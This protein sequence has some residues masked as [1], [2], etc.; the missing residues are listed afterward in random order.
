MLIRTDADC[1]RK[2]V[3][4]QPSRGNSKHPRIAV[5]VTFSA[6]R[7]RLE[8]VCPFSSGRTL[9]TAPETEILAARRPVQA[10]WISLSGHVRKNA[11]WNV[12]RA[13]RLLRVVV[14]PSSSGPE[15]MVAPGMAVLAARPPVSGDSTS[16][17]GHVLKTVLGA[18]KRARRLLRAVT[19][20]SFR[21]PEL[22]VVLGTVQR[23]QVPPPEGTW[24][25]FSGR[26]CKGAH[27]TRKPARVPFETGT[28][29]RWSG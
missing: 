15:F 6:R 5:G 21:G 8:V 19:S 24:R 10:I 18:V 14:S 17:S 26:G 28:W 25:C 11:L 20:A 7:L 13:R 27:G 29:A 22:T 16:C 2:L 9:T 1:P 12:K 3:S 23:A 4:K